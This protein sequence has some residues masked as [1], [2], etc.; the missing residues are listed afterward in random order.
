MQEETFADLRA[1][2]GEEWQ[3][4]FAVT[5]ALQHERRSLDDRLNEICQ[6]LTNTLAIEAAAIL[7]V[8]PSS[9]RL[10]VRGR[11]GLSDTYVRLINDERTLGL[12]ADPAEWAPT[13]R[14]FKL[15]HLVVVHDVYADASFAPWQE[16][17]RR[18]GYVSF[19]AVPLTVRQR[20]VGCL[21]GYSRQRGR[22]G[23]AEVRLLA[24]LAQFLAIA[25]ELAQLYGA[26]KSQ[27]E[28]L[29]RTQRIHEALTTAAFQP[30]SLEAVATTL[31][32]LLDA[33]VL[34]L[35][36][37]LRP[38]ARS[39]GVTEVLILW[40]QRELEARLASGRRSREPFPLPN[41][42]PEV[43]LGL[44]APALSHDRL[45]GHVVLFPGSA[46]V[47][48]VA[49]RGLEQAATVAALS[50]SRE[51]AQREANFRLQTH[52]LYELL[53]DPGPNLAALR[54]RAA[55]VGFSP[56]GPYTVLLLRP[57]HERGEPRPWSAHVLK[58]LEDLL[59]ER[60][61]RALFGEQQGA[62]A[63]VVEGLLRVDDV[64][65]R[66]L[67]GIVERH[68]GTASLQL[69]VGEPAETLLE[70]RRTYREAH[71]TL[72]VAERLG[73]T[74]PCLRQQDL[75]V[76]RFLLDSRSPEA[77]LGFARRLLAPILRYELE[78][79]VPLLATLEA[80]F[81]ANGDIRQVAGMLHLH[82]NT[83][84]YRLDKV[85]ELSGRHLQDMEYQVELQLA[86][87]TV[88]FVGRER[89]LTT[90]EPR[91]FG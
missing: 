25:T 62:L 75:G 54:R 12:H 16:A 30:N 85:A 55:S 37:A 36:R 11:H 5:E 35:D 65:L 53:Q 21:N 69:V 87:A 40:A 51:L 57:L 3:L 88:R 4:V 23:E 76:Y 80:F 56:D 79:G 38:V 52:F 74:L 9:N 32:H 77:L 31:G 72:Q 17:A 70:L 48:A 47:D 15:G 84:R 24:V 29:D 91:D 13:T 18:E 60:G 6:R 49:L 10:V 33:E 1:Q 61:H 45:Y 39:P 63:V 19:I 20:V 46:R 66:Q 67:Q 81:R 83:V 89:F 7:L 86:L 71:Q 64:L 43:P 2:L 41:P 82:P 22:F 27:Y 26:L 68:D 73:V 42:P 50:F 44:A 78:K 28:L 58:L 34:I 59:A 8:D 90:D 14:A